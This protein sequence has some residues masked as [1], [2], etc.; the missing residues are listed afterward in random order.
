MVRDWFSFLPDLPMGFWR[1]FY[2]LTFIGM[3]VFFSGP[4][5]SAQ[6]VAPTPVYLQK[7]SLLIPIDEPAT[8]IFLTF[9]DGPTAK[10]SLAMARVLS[11]HRA[12]GTFFVVGQRA[13]SANS[14]FIMSNLALEGHLIANHTF[15][16]S[17]SY[18]NEAAFEGALRAGTRAIAD[19]LPSSGLVFFRSPGGVW[20]QTR[21]RWTNQSAGGGRD[22]EFASYVGPIHWNVGSGITSDGRAITDAADWQCWNQGASPEVCAIGYLNRI[23]ANY[24]AGRPSI[25]LLHDLDLKSVR[26]LELIF[27][28]LAQDGVGY[29]FKRLDS[30]RWPTSY[31]SF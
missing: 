2:T 28:G 17:R 8:S 12:Y 21:L 3:A 26:L 31:A 13:R 23:R 16:H 14:R 6:P 29:E 24:A 1:G 25:V 11:Q 20:N 22:G 19:F 7:T 4:Y 9:D 15:D 10:V 18:A 27:Q 30:A 5:L